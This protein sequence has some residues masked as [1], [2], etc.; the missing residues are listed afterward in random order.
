M[1][2]CFETHCNIHWKVQSP[3]YVLKQLLDFR[4]DRQMFIVSRVIQPATHSS[5]LFINLHSNTVQYYT[6]SF[7]FSQSS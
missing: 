6:L 3:G 7:S 2:V 1:L 5:V 4:T